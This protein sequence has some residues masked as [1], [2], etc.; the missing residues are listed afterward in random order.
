MVGW[1]SPAPS[2]GRCRSLPL[3]LSLHP[4]FILMYTHD[5]HPPKKTQ[6]DLTDVEATLKGGKAVLDGL[7]GAESI[8]YS[9]YYKAALEYHKAR[10][11]KFICTDMSQQLLGGFRCA[12]AYVDR[13]VGNSAVLTKSNHPHPIHTYKNKIK[14][15]KNKNENK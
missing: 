1:W 2:W 3:L 9:N 7:A 6:G 5:H 11:F 12:H 13:A 15:N 10:L 14:N 8:V 4:P